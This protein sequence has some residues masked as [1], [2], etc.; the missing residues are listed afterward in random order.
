[1]CATCP[2][3]TI[4]LTTLICSEARGYEVLIFYPEDASSIFLQ[5]VGIH[6]TDNKVSKPRSS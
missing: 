3:H 6:P 1:M 2:A 4:V 5:K